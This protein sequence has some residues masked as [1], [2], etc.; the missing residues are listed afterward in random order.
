MKFAA[1]FEA[2]QRTIETAKRALQ[3]VQSSSLLSS[4]ASTQ[5]EKVPQIG[6][7]SRTLCPVPDVLRNVAG[8][9]DV[10]QPKAISTGPVTTSANNRLTPKEQIERLKRGPPRR[11]Y[12]KLAAKLGVSK[13]TI[14]AI[15]K[16]S[17]WVSDEMYCVVASACGCKP[18]DL[19]P[20]DLPP[21]KSRR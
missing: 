8:V 20:R 1:T 19:H 7:P 21:P 16:E 17:R 3:R 10:E 14:Y 18:E 13:D 11:S 4:H 9:P 12:E 5:G 2:C 6:S 15:T